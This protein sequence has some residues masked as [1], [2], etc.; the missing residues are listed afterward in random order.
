MHQV[1]KRDLISKLER[2]DE[3]EIIL[4]PTYHLAFTYNYGILRKVYYH[5]HKSLRLSAVLPSP[6]GLAFRN[7]KN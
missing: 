4:V 7:S 1:D 2:N 3:D 5:I 6:P